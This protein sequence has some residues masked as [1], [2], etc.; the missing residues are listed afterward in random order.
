MCTFLNADQASGQG[1]RGL[2]PHCAVLPQRE[3]ERDRQQMVGRD[4]VHECDRRAG[5]D[6]RLEGGRVRVEVTRAEQAQVRCGNEP[7][8][9]CLH[10]KRLTVL[11]P[12][13]RVPFTKGNYLCRAR[14][15]PG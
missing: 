13:E 12:G 15:G 6:E 9:D 4:G 11:W 1:R 14:C 5:W 3:H 10:P 2:P 8:S 7:T